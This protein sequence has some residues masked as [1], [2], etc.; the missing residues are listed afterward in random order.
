MSQHPHKIF[1]E[2]FL[3]NTPVLGVQSA[4]LPHECPSEPRPSIH[5]TFSSRSAAAPCI[6]EWCQKSVGKQ[7][8]ECNPL[9]W[10]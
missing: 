6:L 5:K 4:P 7:H 2:L 1:W 8:R 3:T 10:N 9:D